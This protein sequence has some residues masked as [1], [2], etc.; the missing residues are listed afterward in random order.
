MSISTDSQCIAVMQPYL[1]PYL[2]YFQLIGAVD[3]FVLYD[4]LN[5]I[6]NGWINRNRILQVNRSPF[7]FTLPV[8][9]RNRSFMKI[10]DVRI[11]RGPWRR[12][13]LNSI[14]L[15]YKCS[16]FFED[17]FPVLENFLHSDT[18]SLSELNKMSIV[19]LSEFLQL[20]TRIITDPSLDNLEDML[21]KEDRYLVTE[22]P[23]LDLNIG[24][25]KIA[26]ALFLC[27]YFKADTFINPIGGLDLYPKLDFARNSIGVFFL[28]MD[29]VKYRQRSDLF[30]P[31]LSIIDVLM[32]C[33]K[34][35]T[36]ELLSKFSLL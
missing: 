34:N 22:F 36:Q 2:G 12:K 21:A 18:D 29:E 10:R 7:Y 9:K 15:N 35:G 6:K 16:T 30:Y 23:D 3:T 25:T 20:E 32:N 1:F 8:A 28:K 17:V 31:N 19:G 33:G 26:R 24:S 14:F 5:Y 27:K 4:N 11:Q 13:L